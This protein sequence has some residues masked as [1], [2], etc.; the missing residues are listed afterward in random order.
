M[1]SGT[2]QPRRDHGRRAGERLPA[3]W[4]LFAGLILLTVG[5]LAALW[6]LG[7]ILNNEVV[8]IGGKG[9]LLADITTWGWVHLILGSLIAITGLGLF[10]GVEWAR[11]A[12]IFLVTANAIAQIVWFPAAPLWAF[13]MI[14]LDVAIIY[15]LT[16]RW[17]E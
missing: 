7:A 3:G 12:A 17:E 4:T 11:F 9:V 6:G 1:E 13:L 8:L 5:S 14:V 2:P 10:A 15:H 16:M